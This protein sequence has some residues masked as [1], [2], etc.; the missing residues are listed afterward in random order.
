MAVRLTI[1]YGMQ[2]LFLLAKAPGFTTTEDYE[3]EQVRDFVK[4]LNRSE[5][6]L[7]RDEGKCIC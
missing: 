6:T 4:T 3:P 7:L 2:S 5:L 1:D